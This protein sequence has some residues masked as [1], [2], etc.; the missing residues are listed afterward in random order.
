[1]IPIVVLL[2]IVVLV[3]IAAAVS[4]FRV[5]S[6]Y[7]LAPVAG[8]AC[9][10]LAAICVF[11]VWYAHGQGVVAARANEPTISKMEK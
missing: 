3:L 2:G 4:C 9:L 7:F 10:I 1:M 11:L 5:G 8:V 6:D